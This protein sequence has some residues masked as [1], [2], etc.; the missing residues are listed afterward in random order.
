MT[1]PASERFRNQLQ[2]DTLLKKIACHESI[3]QK[4]ERTAVE[5][6]VAL[7]ASIYR[8]LVGVAPER[9]RNLVAALQP[10]R[11]DGH[12]SVHDVIAHVNQLKP[13]SGG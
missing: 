8:R 13:S 3:A 7:F 6:E 12:R 10:V 4:W 5:R 2:A 9:R 11:E 1:L